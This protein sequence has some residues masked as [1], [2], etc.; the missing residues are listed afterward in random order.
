MSR[1]VAPHILKA[2]TLRG[3]QSH[4]CGLGLFVLANRLVATT[5]RKAT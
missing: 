3:P 2:T 4:A 5:L 1:K